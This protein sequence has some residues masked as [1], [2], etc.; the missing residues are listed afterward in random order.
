MNPTSTT[1]KSKQSFWNFVDNVTIGMTQ[2]TN[3]KAVLTVEVNFFLP[4][5]IG[6]HDKRLG[7]IDLTRWNTIRQSTIHSLEESKEWHESWKWINSETRWFTQLS[8]WYADKCHVE[9]WKTSAI[10]LQNDSL[11]LILPSWLM[12]ASFHFYEFKENN[13]HSI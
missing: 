9:R 13:K 5:N 8:E 11:P 12:S 10:Y 4:L 7:N 3:T 1:W 6:Q 2:S